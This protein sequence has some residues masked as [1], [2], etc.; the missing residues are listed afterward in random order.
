M[1]SDGSRVA[2]SVDFTSERRT[3]TH[4]SDRGCKTA[5]ATND[6]KRICFLPV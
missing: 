1:C 3:G 5:A 4:S 2:I 6:L